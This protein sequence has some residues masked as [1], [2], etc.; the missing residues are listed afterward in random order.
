MSNGNRAVILDPQRMHLAEHS[1]QDWVV[2]VEAG[3]TVEDILEPAY[4]SHIASSM[5]PFDRIDA[6]METGEWLLELIVVECGR[7]WARVHLAKKHELQAV[8]AEAPPALKHRVEWKG[9]QHKHVVI[10]LADNEVIQSGFSDKAAAQ[11][12]LAQHEQ[13]TA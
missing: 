9:P 11:Q 7:N 13:V 2:N 4:W 3:T 8:V 5:E 6:R 10:R 12:W 1:R